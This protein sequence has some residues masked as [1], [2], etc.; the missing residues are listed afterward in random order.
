MLKFLLNKGIFE[1][2]ALLYIKITR[3]LFKKTEF[4]CA[5]PH[6]TFKTASFEC[7]IQFFM[8]KTAIF[9]FTKNVYKFGFF[10]QA[11]EP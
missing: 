10:F 8:F 2:N 5:K 1:S 7:E 9:K 11:F 4:L 3:I 6:S